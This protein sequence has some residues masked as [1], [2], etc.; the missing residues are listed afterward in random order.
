M[1]VHINNEIGWE[2]THLMFMTKMTC[3][4][5][6]NEIDGGLPAKCDHT[7]Q[8]CISQSVSRPVLLLDDGLETYFSRSRWCRGLHCGCVLLLNKKNKQKKKKVSPI[9]SKLYNLNFFVKAGVI[10]WL[11][12]TVIFKSKYHIKHIKLPSSSTKQVGWN[13]HKK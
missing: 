9:V 13:C 10:V 12:P 6:D 2:R 11:L 7:S 1:D 3:V 8:L 5:R 4:F